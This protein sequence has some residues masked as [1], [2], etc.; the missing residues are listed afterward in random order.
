[1][2]K[3]KTL[4]IADRVAIVLRPEFRP[5]VLA[6]QFGE[7]RSC[8]PLAGPPIARPVSVERMDLQYA[9]VSP[10]QQRIR[11]NLQSPRRGSHSFR[12]SPPKGTTISCS[13]WDE[14]GRTGRISTTRI[15]IRWLFSGFWSARQTLP[16]SSISASYCGISALVKR[17]HHSRQHRHTRKH[18]RTSSCCPGLR[19]LGA[20]A[21]Q[22][23]ST[24]RRQGNLRDP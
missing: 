22:W 4:N 21:L 6:H 9:G 10:R 11:T 5:D 15:P 12:E 23:R 2:R 8:H 19:T 7:T 17:R 1:M 3:R 14:T 20:D 18:H 16:T 13:P 24:R